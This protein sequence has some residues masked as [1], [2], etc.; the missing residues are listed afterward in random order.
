M[1]EVNFKY[2]CHDCGTNHNIFNVTINGD[3]YQEI[4]LCSDY[5]ED[6]KETLEENNE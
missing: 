6:R 1:Y 2:I 4:D 5:L 3:E